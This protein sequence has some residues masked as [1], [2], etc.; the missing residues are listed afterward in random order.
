MRA[1]RY[2]YITVLDIGSSKISGL[3]AKV[4]VMPNQSET[5]L[6]PEN[7][8][9]IACHT[10]PSSGIVGGIIDTV[11]LVEQ[12]I[13]ALILKLEEK[14]KRRI[15][16]VWIN[17]S[18]GNPKTEY[19][20]LELKVNGFITDHHIA[21]LHRQVVDDMRQEQK[22]IM[23]AIPA[24]FEVDGSVVT[25]PIGMQADILKANMVFITGRLSELRNL[26]IS[27]EKAHIEIS[28]R[29]VT[30]ISSALGCLDET[31][32]TTGSVCIDIG[33]ETIG[34]CAFNKNIPF[35][36]EI[37]KMGG[38]YITK[39]I[40]RA[41]G[42][43]LHSAE[44][45]KKNYGACVSHIHDEKETL[46][47][48]I[49]GSDYD[50]SGFETRPKSHLTQI[51]IPRTEEMLELLQKHLSRL[52]LLSPS[53]R[54]VFTGG[55]AS[56]RGIET[57]ATKMLGIR[58]RIA[59][60]IAMTTLPQDISG[61]EYSTLVGLLFYA[62]NGFNELSHSKLFTSLRTKK[63]ITGKFLNWLVENF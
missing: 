35:Y 55:G 6:I 44:S 12:T 16:T 57:L 26:G 39:D 34:I 11:E 29:V 27:V 17:A 14:S 52:G 58:P 53:N 9:I 21:K 31:E 36:V 51:I 5:K 48:P 38:S 25:Q 20:N 8:E 63:G 56:L 62:L 49:I 28:G 43:G 22:Y 42:I 15:D 45:I 24:G 37:L 3:C 46:E 61:P 47:L 4:K 13:T 2:K 32:K 23:H 60:P 59:C 10:L 1:I 40:A 7:F 50:V 18:M 33:A 19:K 41:F 54:I 30:P